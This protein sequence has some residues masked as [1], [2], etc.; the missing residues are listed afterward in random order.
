MLK[1][2]EIENFGSYQNFNGLAEKNYFKKMNK[3]SLKSKHV[4][5]SELV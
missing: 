1:N 4:F 5:F 2:I 3:L